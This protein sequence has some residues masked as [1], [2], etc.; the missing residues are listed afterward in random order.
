MAEIPSEE[1]VVSW[2]DSL[3]NWGRWGEDDQL[4]TL[5][6]VTPEVRRAAAATVTEGVS[7]SCAW[8]IENT[9]EPDHAMGTPQ[10]FMVAT[11]ESAAAMA[12][13]GVS[14]M[15]G[16]LEFFGLVYHG[17][18]IT[19]LDGLCHI[20]WDGKMYN[21]RPAHL[22]NSARGAANLPITELR[23][24]IATR[25]VLL[26]VAAAK[27]ADWM[28]PGEGVF[29]EDLEAAEARQG[30]Q[31]RPGDAVLLRTGYGRRKR[32]VGREP[33]LETGFPGWHVA[34]MPWLKERGA[35]VIGADTATDVN[36]SGYP[37]LRIPVHAVG[38][39]AMGLWL[40]DNMQ[41][42]D[43]AAKAAE[44][45]RWEFQFVL[46]PLRIIGSTGSPANP[47]AIF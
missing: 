45:G 15:G 6:L 5:N 41:L 36:P 28:Q 44:L 29:P 46:S 24:G 38:I 11:G 2:M 27:G 42:E 21:G 1:T 10:R 13:S 18:A 25:G 26:D 30:V 16:A 39:V 19:H 37:Q 3:S 4:G 7:V 22:V 32:E 31:V 47:L 20:F 34:C 8:D 40:I 9:H 14:R 35:A 33:L 12:E 43:A 23:D 17:Y